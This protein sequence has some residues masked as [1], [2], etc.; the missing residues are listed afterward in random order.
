MGVVPGSAPEPLQRE[1]VCFA[2]EVDLFFYTKDRLVEFQCDAHLQVTTASRGPARLSSGGESKLP[3][4]FVEDIRKIHS[5]IAEAAQVAQP[6]TAK[7][8][9]AGALVRIREHAV[10]FVDFFELLFRVGFFVHVRMILTRQFPERG[11]DLILRRIPADAKN[12]VVIAIRHNSR[13]P[14][15]DH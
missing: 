6:L 10:G 2:F 13:E 11:F 8:V 14:R 7:A 9:V 3:K 15:T 4:E 1:Q 5:V 12:I